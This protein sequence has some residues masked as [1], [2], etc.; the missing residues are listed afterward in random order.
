MG[1]KT[2]TCHVNYT[3]SGNTQ[4]KPLNSG[5]DLIVTNTDYYS[6][7]PDLSTCKAGTIND[8]T[9]SSVVN[10][11]NYIRGLHGLSPLKYNKDLEVYTSGA[12][13]AMAAQQTTS[14]DVDNSW[15]CYTENGATG[16]KYSSLFNLSSAN[17]GYRTT[18]SDS[19]VAYMRENTSTSLGHRRWMLDPFIKETAFGMADG[20]QKT[21]G[22][23]YASGASLYMY[24]PATYASQTTTAP[25][26]IYPY[27]VGNYPQKYYKKGDRMSF[28]VLYD[29]SSYN[30][31]RNVDYSK[32]TLTITDESGATHAATDIL[33]DNYSQ[34]VPNQMSFLLPDFAYGVKYIVKVDNVMVNGTAQNYGYNF[35]VN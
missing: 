34:A 11:V 8:A 17:A 10:E 9:R 30:K 21:T 19:L 28:Y 31:N 4:Y 22:R 25:L 20:V 33:Y 35:T 7:K 15:L 2:G 14:H 6:D 12:A 1:A 26:G 3:Q 27:P 32:A 13:L 18:P 5:F 29:Q 16:A 23:G 24:N